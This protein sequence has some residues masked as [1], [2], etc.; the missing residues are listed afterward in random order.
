MKRQLSKGFLTAA[1]CC[2]VVTAY[3]QQPVN[4]INGLRVRT[5]AFVGDP[6]T[7]KTVTPAPVGTAITPLPSSLIY[8]ETNFTNTGVGFQANRAEFLLSNDAGATGRF[9][10]NTFGNQDAFDI[11]FDLTLEAQAATP[12][13]EAGIRINFN[14]FDGLFLVNT[15]AGEIVAFG[16]TLPFYSFNV[17]NGLSYTA[18][19]TINM[20]MVYTPPELD[21]ANMVVEPGTIEYIVDE[22]AGPVSSMPIE[23]GGIEGG[24][25]DGSTVGLHVQATGAINDTTDFVRATWADFDFEGAA[26]VDDADFDSDGDVDGQDFLTWQRGLGIATGA[27]M[28]QGDA[29]AD[30]DVDGDDLAVWRAQF[31]GGAAVPTISSIPEPT[32]VLLALTGALA[33]IRIRA[34][35]RGH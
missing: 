27:T 25:I 21:N 17:T 24:I 19:E 33:F 30:G 34:R 23:F 14:G 31:G 35:R 29:N 13:K 18:G 26:P 20:R 22:G 4:D 16:G 9:F 1:A 7:V 8:H 12:R 32:S 5:S 6:G 3:A 2:C 15:D 11:S 10:R 28:E